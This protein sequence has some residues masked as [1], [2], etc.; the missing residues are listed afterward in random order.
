LVR[1]LEQIGGHY[2]GRLEEQEITNMFSD[3]VW[4]QEMLLRALAIHG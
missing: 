3:F 4:D 2:F 1:Q